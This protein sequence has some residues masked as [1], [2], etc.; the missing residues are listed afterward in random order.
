MV[1]R[2]RQ[3]RRAHTCGTTTPSTS[4]YLFLL[5]ADNLRL[6]AVP[7]V[8]SPSTCG[9]KQTGD[10]QPQTMAC[11]EKLPRPRSTKLCVSVTAPRGARRDLPEGV[12]ATRCRRSLRSSP[13]KCETSAD[14]PA[15]RPPQC[16]TPIRLRSPTDE[17]AKTG[18]SPPPKHPATGTCKMPPY[19]R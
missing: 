19:C 12:A 3:P 11:W 9:P 10:R 13:T 1:T 15:R 5:R 16:A 17:R 14:V 18:E 4:R 2:L 6:R 7:I 8:R